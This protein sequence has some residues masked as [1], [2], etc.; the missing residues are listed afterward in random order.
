MWKHQQLMHV[1]SKPLSVLAIITVIALQKWINIIL[2]PNRY[3]MQCGLVAI[4]DGRAIQISKICIYSTI[5][6]FEAW[7]MHYIDAIIKT[8]QGKLFYT[9][10]L[11]RIAKNSTVCLLLSN[12]ILASCC[13]KQVPSKVNRKAVYTKWQTSDACSAFK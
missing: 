10:T 2:N 3:S 1:C 9:N 11:T 5:I 12:A 7:A 8:I 13:C 6:N 4:S